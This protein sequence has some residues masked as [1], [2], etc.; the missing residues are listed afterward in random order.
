MPG[1]SP[2]NATQSHGINWLLN[3]GMNRVF[4]GV[5]WDQYSDGAFAVDQ[6]YSTYSFQVADDGGA[7]IYD[8][9]VPIILDFGGDAPQESLLANWSIEGAVGQLTVYPRDSVTDERVTAF[10]GPDPVRVSFA[11]T[12]QIIFTQKISVFA[13]LLDRPIT[14]FGFLRKDSKTVDLQIELDFGTSVVTSNAAPSTGY[15]LGGYL[16]MAVTP[17]Y[18]ATQFVV[19][20]K[21]SG[22]I[23][24]AVY[25]GQFGIYLG[26]LSQVLFVEDLSERGRPRG[27]CAFYWGFPAPPGYK[28]LCEEDGRLLFHTAGDAQVDGMTETQFGGEEEHNHR[29]VTGT[30]DA[31]DNPKADGAYV[32]GRNHYH[33]VLPAKMEP[34][35]FKVLVIEKI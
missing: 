30:A 23:S 25:V 10:T 4:R 21:M 11:E 29:A 33:T 13:H 22:L 20:V 27:E 19:R 24:S 9:Y 28:T 35:N 17:P 31:F 12:G 2:G 3:G 5:V 26:D 34:L 1:G 16:K 14:V 18:D 6:P 15:P 32:L 8:P 7:G